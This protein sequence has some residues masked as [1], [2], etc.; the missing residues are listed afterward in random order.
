M[1]DSVEHVALKVEAIGPREFVMLVPNHL[2]P[3]HDMQP[4]D[5]VPL[6][7]AMF[8]TMELGGWLFHDWGEDHSTHTEACF[9]PFNPEG[10]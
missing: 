9:I 5:T 8:A 1:N 3:E 7:R 2:L 4:E 6:L 10:T